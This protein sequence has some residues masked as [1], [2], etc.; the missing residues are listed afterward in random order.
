MGGRQSLWTLLVSNDD[1]RG[2]K[3]LPLLKS[4]RHSA[5]IPSVS[6]HSTTSHFFRSILYYFR[7]A[8]PYPIRRYV[9]FARSVTL[10]QMDSPYLMTVQYMCFSPFLTRISI[11]AYLPVLIFV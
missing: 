10:S 5:R 3:T 11:L 7:P 1:S 8:E 6:V 2:L 4:D 9:M